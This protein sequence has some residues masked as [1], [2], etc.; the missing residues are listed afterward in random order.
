M[1]KRRDPY[2]DVVKAV[3]IIMVVFCHVMTIAPSG[4][5]PMWINNFRVGMNMP[6]F[7]VIS[8]YFAWPMVEALDWRKL[9]RNVR[10][11]LTP[12]LFAGVVYAA[13][14]F[15]ITPPP[16]PPPPIVCHCNRDE[17]CKERIRRSLVC[18]DINRMPTVV[19]LVL[20][21]WT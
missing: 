3:A 13:A 9:V 15:L 11:Y 8:G 20:G 21:G 6:I 17:T 18:Y 19:I 7:F 14:D 5:F 4:T 10:A 1:I 2:F 16:P 12:A